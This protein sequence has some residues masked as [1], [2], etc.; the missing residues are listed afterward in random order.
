MTSSSERGDVVVA[1]SS[2]GGNMYHPQSM[3]LP[4]PHMAYPNFPGTIVPVKVIFILPPEALIGQGGTCDY[5]HFCL[6]IPM[7]ACVKAW[8]IPFGGGGGL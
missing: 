3:G 7:I 1:S 5:S 2:S 6:I 8:G 4:Q